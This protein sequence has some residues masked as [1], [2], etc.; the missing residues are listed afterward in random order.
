MKNASSIHFN[1]ASIPS[2]KVNYSVIFLFSLILNVKRSKI[3][4]FLLQWLNHLILYDFHT[5]FIQKFK[6]LLCEH[7]N[8]QFDAE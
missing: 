4:N 7:L 2:A 6:T 1:Y 8:K 5:Y 3:D